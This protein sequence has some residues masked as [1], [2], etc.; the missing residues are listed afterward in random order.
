MH[1]SYSLVNPTCGCEKFDGLYPQGLC[2]TGFCSKLNLRLE[3][4]AKVQL[5]QFEGLYIY[6]V[7][8]WNGGQW[9]F[10]KDRE[11]SI[12][13]QGGKNW[14]LA[15]SYNNNAQIKLSSSLQYGSCPWDNTDTWRYSDGSNS[16]RTNDVFIECVD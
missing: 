16:F 11:Y 7:E 6:K 4:D 10:S 1:L 12:A 14:R 9:V 2:S 3:N 15:Y 8:Y 13:S 5:G